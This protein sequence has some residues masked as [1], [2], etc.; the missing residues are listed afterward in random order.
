MSDVEMQA[1]KQ[2]VLDEQE[3]ERNRLKI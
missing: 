1:D 2:A 3:L